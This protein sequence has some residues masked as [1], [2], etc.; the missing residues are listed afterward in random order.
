MGWGDTRPL[1]DRK[2]ER[3]PELCDTCG[4]RIKIIPGEKTTFPMPDYCLSGGKHD[5]KS[6]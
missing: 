1:H 3:D 6:S 5:K 4:G 2:D